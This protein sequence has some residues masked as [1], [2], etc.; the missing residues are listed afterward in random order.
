MTLEEALLTLK[1]RELNKKLFAITNIGELIE[2]IAVLVHHVRNHK[3]IHVQIVSRNKYNFE[4]YI[5]ELVE[6]IT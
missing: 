3:A 5:D 6:I 2:C 1:S 4:K